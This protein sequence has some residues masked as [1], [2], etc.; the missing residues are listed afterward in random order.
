M[1][2][3]EAAS[4]CIRGRDAWGKARICRIGGETAVQLCLTARD[5]CDGMCRVYLQDGRGGQIELPGL[6]LW[7]GEG[8]MT[9]LEGRLTPWQAAGMRICVGAPR[10]GG[11][12]WGE[13]QW[14]GDGCGPTYPESPS[15]CGRPICP[16]IPNVCVR[17]VCPGTPV[18]CGRP[19]LPDCRPPER[20]PCP[21]PEPVPWRPNWNRCGKPDGNPC[22]Q[23]V[24]G[25]CGRPGGISPPLW[26]A[27]PCGG[28]P[29]R[30]CH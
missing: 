28:K 4:A 5:W 21:G 12:A 13:F 16:G 8:K 17:P 24:W 27:P 6:P 18:G 9:Y 7:D 23:P 26:P 10:G 14:D 25:G 2:N 20:R 19:S 11:V 22:M 29:V 3:A 1:R 15:G 30:Q